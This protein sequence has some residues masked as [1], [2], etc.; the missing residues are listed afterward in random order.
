MIC[1]RSKWC[2]GEDTESCS[3]HL[4]IQCA[5]RWECEENGSDG[6]RGS[7]SLVA[8]DHQKRCLWT[9]CFV[10]KCS[11]R[12]LEMGIWRCF[13]RRVCVRND[14]FRNYKKS[15]CEVQGSFTKLNVWEIVCSVGFGWESMLNAE[16]CSVKVSEKNVVDDWWLCSGSGLSLFGICLS[17]IFKSVDAW[18]LYL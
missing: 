7:G 2:S 3:C 5:C 12:M 17:P 1:G 14:W 10:S 15:P 18:F 9:T 16:F 8:V 4:S 13:L 6:L 11:C